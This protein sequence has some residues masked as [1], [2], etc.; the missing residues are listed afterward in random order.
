MFVRH[1][2]E[3]LLSCYLDK[4]VES[5]HWSLPPYRRYVHETARNL[6]KKRQL[7]QQQQR[8]LAAAG[9]V[10]RIGRVLHAAAET[11]PPPS[12]SLSS[13][14]G[15]AEEARKKL[16]A[17]FM[18]GIDMDGNGTGPK[19]PPSA[20]AAAYSKLP[21]VTPTFEGFSSSSSFSRSPSRSLSSS[22]TCFR[23]V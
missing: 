21:P 15:A 9:A 17:Q 4:M 5:T 19:Q 2:M 14:S 16:L 6:L 13:S 11:P 22:V 20:A 8:Q 3:R 1:P 18:D 12:S 10:T 7:Q 23:G